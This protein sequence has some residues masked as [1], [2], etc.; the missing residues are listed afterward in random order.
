MD[1][2]ARSTLSSDSKKILPL[3]NPPL[4]ARIGLQSQELEQIEVSCSFN[5][6]LK[7]CDPKQSVLDTFSV[8]LPAATTHPYDSQTFL[9]PYYRKI[10]AKL[11]LLADI[12]RFF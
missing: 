4:G 7:L 12:D 5:L 9:T 10:I 2:Q 6:G 3:D 1:N 8:L 11:S